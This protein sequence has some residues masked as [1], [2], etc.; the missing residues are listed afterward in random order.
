MVFFG[1]DKRD[2]GPIRRTLRNRDDEMWFNITNMKI[3]EPLEVIVDD[4][5]NPV[6]VKTKGGQLRMFGS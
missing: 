6:S 4:D 1:L 3:A 2:I 5:G